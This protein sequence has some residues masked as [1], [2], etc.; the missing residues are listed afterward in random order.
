MSLGDQN[1]GTVSFQV[2]TS[3][4]LADRAFRGLWGGAGFD[5]VVL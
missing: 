4:G 1:H 3:Y 2:A 5:P